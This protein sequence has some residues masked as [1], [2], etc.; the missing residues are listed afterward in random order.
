MSSYLRLREDRCAHTFWLDV[1]DRVIN[2]WVFIH[3]TSYHQ[4]ITINL[5]DPPS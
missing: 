4:S 3:G 2:G 1:Y 5:P